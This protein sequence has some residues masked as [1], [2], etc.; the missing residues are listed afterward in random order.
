MIS[1]KY[2][3]DG[4]ELILCYNERTTGGEICRG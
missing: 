2:R 4:Y 1:V 3:K